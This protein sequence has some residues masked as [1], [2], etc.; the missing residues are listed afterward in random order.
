MFA[1]NNDSRRTHSLKQNSYSNRTRQLVANV[2]QKINKSLTL[3]S[4]KPDLSQIEPIL[5]SMYDQLKEEIAD[6]D[7]ALECFAK[8]LIKP[9]ARPI[10]VV[11]NPTANFAVNVGAATPIPFQTIVDNHADFDFSNG[12]VTPKRRGWYN[13]YGHC[14]DT[15]NQ[16]VLTYNLHILSQG[17][18]SI[19]DYHYNQNRPFKLM[20]QAYVYC[21]GTTDTITLCLSHNGVLVPMLFHVPDYQHLSYMTVSWVGNENSAFIV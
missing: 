17:T 18:I 2:T 21:N 5:L 11:K 19:V 14:Y 12:V 16:A 8:S 4:A 13:V 6:R 7:R 15:Y 3:I 10:I 9:E 1:H 20:G